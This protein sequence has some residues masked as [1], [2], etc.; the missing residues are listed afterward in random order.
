MF[1]DIGGPSCRKKLGGYLKIILD[2]ICPTAAELAQHWWN[3]PVLAQER[4]LSVCHSVCLSVCMS[5][6]L[7][8]CLPVWSSFCLS[9]G[10]RSS[11]QLATIKQTCSV[12]DIHH[13]APPPKTI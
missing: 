6:C 13:I 5:L 11:A 7:S 9:V 3:E 2:K 1:S 10:P 8:V 4:V 12:P